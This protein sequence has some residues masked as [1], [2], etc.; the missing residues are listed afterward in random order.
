MA[1]LSFL[2]RF[3]LPICIIHG[4]FDI[5]GGGGRLYLEKYQAHDSSACVYSTAL[6]KRL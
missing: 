4:Q 1:D 6:N 5:A 3:V 2:V